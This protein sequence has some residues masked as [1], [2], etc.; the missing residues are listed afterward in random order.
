MASETDALIVSVCTNDESD[1]N[2]KS[3]L[4][5][6]QLLD[7]VRGSGSMTGCFWPMQDG[8]EFRSRAQKFI[9]GNRI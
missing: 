1:E 8:D 3:R 9:N 7:Q 5:A 4:Q 2:V 6:A